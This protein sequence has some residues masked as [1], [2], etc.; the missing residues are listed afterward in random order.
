MVKNG[1]HLNKIISL[2]F[3]VAVLG[4]V[5]TIGF[6]IFTSL[7]T[8]PSKLLQ[9][10]VQEAPDFTA[11]IFHDE[12]DRVLLYRFLEPLNN[13]ATRKYPLV[14]F[15]NGTM[16]RGHNNINQLKYAG[17]F[18]NN[19]DN[20]RKFPCFVIIPQCP[21][22]QNW[23]PKENYF[24]TVSLSPRLA[25]PLH[26]TMKLVLD[27][28]RN[29]NID[30]KR[31]YIMGL[32]SGG[33]GVWDLAARYPKMFAAAVPFAGC[34]DATKAKRLIQTPVWIFHGALDLAVSPNCSRVM[35][36]ALLRAGGRPRYTEYAMTG[37]SCWIKA[38]KDPRLLKWLF[39]KQRQ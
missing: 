10:L 1:H 8:K 22:R 14:V 25:E 9:K 7:Q 27:L 39:A 32:S 18:F 28:R 29:L 19:M 33:S 26:L 16:E 6:K 17:P 24:G 21:A 37:H 3:F 13:D 38:F 31:I 12:D 5:I 11:R 35:Y 2:L 20:R 23:V 15:L 34:G 36:H 30:P 4:L